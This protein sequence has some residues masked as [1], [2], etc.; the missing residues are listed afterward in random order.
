MSTHDAN[1]NAAAARAS[2]PTITDLGALPWPI[3][4]KAQVITEEMRSQSAY[5]TLVQARKEKRRSKR[6]PKTQGQQGEDQ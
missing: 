5:Q 4:E 6:R 2:D 3:R 1:A